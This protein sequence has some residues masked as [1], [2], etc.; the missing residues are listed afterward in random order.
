MVIVIV[1]NGVKTKRAEEMVRRLLESWQAG[2]SQ[3]GGVAVLGC[4][5]RS[6]DS[7]TEVYN[8]DALVWTPHKCAVVEVKGFRSA[9]TGVL[10]PRDNGAWRVDDMVADLYSLGSAANPVAQ[11]QD[12]M[13][14]VKNHFTPA[15]LPDWVELLVVLAPQ[16][17]AR[18][19]I[20]SSQLNRGTF[21][22]AAA[23]GDDRAL[24]DYFTPPPGAKRRWS[25]EDIQ[26]AF[27]V[28]GLT[29]YLPDRHR[30]AREGFSFS[31]PAAQTPAH[32]GDQDDP[33]AHRPAPTRERP[34]ITPPPPALGSRLSP[35]PTTS[36]PRSPATPAPVG[37]HSSD[38]GTSEWGDDGVEHAAPLRPFTPVPTVDQ[39]RRPRLPVSERY[40]LH[41]AATPP[42]FT[43]LTARR[44]SQW[45]GIDTA[46]SVLAIIILAAL[47]VL[48]ARCGDERAASRT[49][50]SVTPPAGQVQPS[51]APPPPA[52]PARTPNTCMPFQTA[53]T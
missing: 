24:R 1:S 19:T 35:P 29:D 45:P 53:C 30:L 28:L 5:V 23:S 17:D 27:G 33:F 44:W 51:P 34:H 10:D 11:A 47:L 4:N 39:P 40:P 13:F 3:V 37:P 18:L 48:V 15:R 6:M 36:T 14:A 7:E 41:P 2:T 52:P 46:V 43:A 49:G 42:A 50:D 22:V 8:L 21:V 12:Y 38:R 25:G 32:P 16:R 9:Q 26:R 31:P 20:T